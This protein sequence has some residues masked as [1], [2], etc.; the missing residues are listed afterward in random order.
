MSSSSDD[1]E[2]IECVPSTVPARLTND[3]ETQQGRLSA[4]CLGPC[5]YPNSVTVNVQWYDS[6]LVHAIINATQSHAFLKYMLSEIRVF[7]SE[8][9]LDRRDVATGIMCAKTILG[10]KI[11]N[12]FDPMA[13]SC[14]IAH[15]NMLDGKGHFVGIR[16]IYGKLCILDSLNGM[17]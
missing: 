4:V 5:I 12:G 9:G 1:C 2:I 11:R 15:V 7:A 3:E 13:H 6:C 17:I 8:E 16:K 10:F 14:G